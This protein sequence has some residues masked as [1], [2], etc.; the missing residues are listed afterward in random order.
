[1][2]ALLA[3][4]LGANA[5][6]R[7]YAKK[8]FKAQDGFELPYQVLYPENFDP[9]T[10]YPL[11]V[12]LHGSGERGDDNSLQTFHG[13]EMLASAPELE[14]VMVIVPQCPIYDTWAPKNSSD[15]GNREFPYKAPMRS[16]LKAVKELMDNMISLGFVNTD[17]IYGTG[18][19]LGGFGILDFALRFPDFFAAVQPIC[20]GT[21]IQRCEEYKGRT[22]F[23]FFHGLEDTAVAPENSIKGNEALQKAGAHSELVTYPGVKHGSWYNAFKEPDFLS[24]MLKY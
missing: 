18:L 12:F 17:R 7:A 2:A 16:P 6:T 20:G 19:S 22:A 1:M 11:L 15:D 4:T 23:R 21:N 24:W 5:E 9:T 10:Q 3:F 13:G 8:T 14:Q